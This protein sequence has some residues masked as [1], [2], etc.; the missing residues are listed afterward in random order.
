LFILIHFANLGPCEANEEWTE[1]FR[2]VILERIGI[3]TD[4]R[5]NLMA[6]VPDKR[7]SL[8]TKVKLLKTNR[9]ASHRIL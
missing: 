6:V 3:A 4:I 7:V 2:K 9:L 1:H 8:I 5:Y